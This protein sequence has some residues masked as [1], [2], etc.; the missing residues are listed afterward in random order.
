[1][2][3]FAAQELEHLIEVSSLLAQQTAPTVQSSSPSHAT[4]RLVP[5][6]Q[7]TPSAT[8]APP[9][10]KPEK[11][12][13]FGTPQPPSPFPGHSK[14]PGVPARFPPSSAASTEASSAPESWTPETPPSSPG[15]G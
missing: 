4:S 1:M 6:G 5:E 11:Q 13:C 14:V 9:A 15:R 12:Q 2:R 8:H 7:L 3:R 10:A